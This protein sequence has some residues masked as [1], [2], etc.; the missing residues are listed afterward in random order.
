MSYK[1]RSTIFIL[2]LIFCSLCYPQQMMEKVC[3]QDTCVQVEIADTVSK[4][5]QGLMFR[6]NLPDNQGMLFIFEREDSYSF[7]M[8]NMQIPL[9]I[10]WIGKD[11]RIVAIKT[12]VPPC[13]DSC[14]GIMPQ[15]KA[16]YVLEVSAGFVEKN[17]VRVGDKVDFSDRIR[18]NP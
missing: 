15:E 10:I 4:R 14:S 2:S 18:E 17:K 12:N 8:K 11:K 5:T 9:D 3:F 1:I 13:K 7:W 6:K 16:Q